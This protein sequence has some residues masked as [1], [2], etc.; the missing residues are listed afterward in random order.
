LL[1]QFV[2]RAPA[3]PENMSFREQFK[4]DGPNMSDPS[5]A[6]SRIYVGNI[7]TSEISKKDLEERFKKHGAILGKMVKLNKAAIGLFPYQEQY[8]YWRACGVMFR[9]Y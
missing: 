5:T 9:K 7:P 1:R 8:C 6:N 4:G 3:S 2:I